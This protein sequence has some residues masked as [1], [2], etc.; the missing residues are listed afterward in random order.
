[1]SLHPV[2]LVYHSQSRTRRILL[3]GS[4]MR[5]RV[6]EPHAELRGS[7]NSN[8]SPDTSVTNADDC[9]AMETALLADGLTA[10]ELDTQYY[11]LAQFYAGHCREYAT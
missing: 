5:R 7:T 11:L 10:D 2:L 8:P 9:S 4:S 1:M 6:P 3:D